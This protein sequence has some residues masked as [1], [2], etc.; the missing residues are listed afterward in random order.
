LFFARH[1]DNFIMTRKFTSIYR[2]LVPF[3]SLIVTRQFSSTYRDWQKTSPLDA[4]GT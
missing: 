4:D 3:K 2:G 1:L